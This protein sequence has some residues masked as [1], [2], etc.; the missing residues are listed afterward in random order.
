MPLE[1]PVINEVIVFLSTQ[2]QN[3][4]T[5]PPSTRG[6]ATL[7]RNARRTPSKHP[8]GVSAEEQMD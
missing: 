8:G 6:A 1:A 2:S 3:D 7:T 4:V 5:P